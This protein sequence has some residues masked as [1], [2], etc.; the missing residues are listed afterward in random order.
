LVFLAAN[1]LP[2]PSKTVCYNNFFQLSVRCN[3]L[4]LPFGFHTYS[5]LPG[6]SV[7]CCP[8]SHRNGFWG[9]IHPSEEIF[10]THNS[11]KSFDFSELLRPTQP[12]TPT[13]IEN[14]TLQA[15]W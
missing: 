4:I 5:Q 1:R 6:R 15:L 9:V 12:T 11:S 13:S 2:L 8:N 10:L 3:R 7:F 14:T